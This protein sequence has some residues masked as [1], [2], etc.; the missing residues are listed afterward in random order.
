MKTWPLYVGLVMEVSVF[1]GFPDGSIGDVATLT[2]EK[3]EIGIR[4]ITG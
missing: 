1:W 4:M 2:L 3:H